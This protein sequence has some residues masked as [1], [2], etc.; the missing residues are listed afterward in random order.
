[1][2]TK[3]QSVAK[4]ASN[5]IM[6]LMAIAVAA[7]LIPACKNSKNQVASKSLKDSVWVQVDE[8]PVFHGGD[9]ALLRFIAE[10][11]TYPENAK[12]NNINGRVIVKFV[13]EKDGSV[14]G[15]SILKGVDP[16]I[17]AEAVKVVRI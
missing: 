13:V 11:T 12:K 15:A 9:T 8:M 7:L 17:D 1:M 14:S 3:N 5:V 16:E 10:N 2:K 6:V 4:S